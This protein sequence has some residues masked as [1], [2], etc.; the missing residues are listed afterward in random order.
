MSDQPNAN[1]RKFLRQ[2]SAAVAA[3]PVVSMVGISSAKA[4]TKAEDGHAHNYVNDAADADHA[5]YSE[6][7]KCKNC[8]FWGGGDDQ[9]GQ[10]FHA[11]F[12][13]VQ[14]NADGW[15]DEYVGA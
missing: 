8:A 14:V 5:D 15:C 7:E 13:G 9:W 4:D 6:G 10:C 1:R 2:A 3:I 11:D 12:Q